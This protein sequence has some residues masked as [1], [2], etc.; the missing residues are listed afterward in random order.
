MAEKYSLS[1]L[2]LIIRDSLYLALPDFYWV[3]AEISE[4]RENNSGHCYLELIE[5]QPEETN[6]RAR[7]KAIV[8]SNRYRFIKSFFENIT[9]DT[10]KEGQKILVKAKVEYHELYGL[11]LIISDID[12]AFTMG[13]MALKRQII[14]QRLE[15][16]GVFTMNQELE[17]PLTPQRI[18]VISSKNA[19]GYSDFIN[20]LSENSFGY[21][22]STHLID[23]T[24]QGNETEKSI[25]K[26]L[27]IIAE[28]CDRFDVVVVIRGGGSQSDLSWFD[29][30]N[31]AYHI[32]QF[33]IPVITGIG[34]EKDMSVT[35]MVA[36]ISLKT[37]TA[38]ADFLIDC[39]IRAENHLMEISSEI[40]NTSK[41]IISDN[42]ARLE[43]CGIKIA[44]LARI[45]LSRNRDM[46]SE[47]IIEIINTGKE[48]NYMAGRITSE[49]ESR[50]ISTIKLLTSEKNRALERARDKLASATTILMKN[51]S[52]KLDGFASN[53]SILNPYNVLSRGY[54]IT[55]INGK[56]MKL[57]NKLKP[58]DVIDT[59]FIDKTVKSKVLE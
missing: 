59:Q 43:A 4:I 22:F 50:L 55:S 21:S 5:K 54:T 33:P 12:P 29:N 10:L 7:I 8:W 24:M 27:D 45:M 3:I 14:I 51:N 35:D 56:I 42:K 41:S 17:L 40:K 53:L 36:N 48:Y 46:L 19:A 26:A 15:K 11:S 32:T 23:S 39:M 16:E 20:H 9:G 58:E 52:V 49:L 44:P 13:D 1:D 6:T 30:Y 28:H 2:Q 25:I 18:A 34:H 37:P 57:G 31:I 47:K 38:V